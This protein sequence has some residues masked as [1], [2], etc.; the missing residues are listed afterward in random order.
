MSAFAH[1]RAL[2]PG[3]VAIAGEVYE[4]AL[5]DGASQRQEFRFTTWPSLQPRA[6]VL[7]AEERNRT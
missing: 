2:I 1:A 6:N 5:V 7:A 3:R 4:P